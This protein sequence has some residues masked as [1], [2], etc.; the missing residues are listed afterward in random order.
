MILPYTTDA[1]LYHPPITTGTL[2]GLNVATFV[3]VMT[4]SVSASDLALSHGD[5]LHPIQWITSNFIHGDVM[6]LLGNMMSLWVFGLVVEGKIGWWRMLLLYLGIGVG[7]CALEQTITLG[8][9]SGESFG[10]SSIIYG[11]MAIAIIWAPSNEVS[12]VTLIWYYPIT[13]E[14]PVFVMG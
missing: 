12:C 5:G 6:H 10:A 14:I 1:P 13:F 7:Q 3:M 2:I 8:M 11:L 4:S 9:S